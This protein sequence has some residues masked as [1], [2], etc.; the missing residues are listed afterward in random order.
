[1]AFTN[2]FLVTLY[3][4]VFLLC[5][6]F[7]SLFNKKL[8]S[9]WTYTWVLYRA[10]RSMSH[11]SGLDVVKT[12]CSTL[13]LS[14]GCQIL[15]MKKLLNICHSI[16]LTYW[17]SISCCIIH[18]DWQCYCIVQYNLQA[19]LYCMFECIWNTDTVFGTGT[20]VFSLF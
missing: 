19:A 6:K 3:H 7:S 20:S 10:W 5:V 16:V 12:C 9:W 8:Y 18:C 17:G 11:V 13:Y 14:L 1:V 15:K 2:G 4:A